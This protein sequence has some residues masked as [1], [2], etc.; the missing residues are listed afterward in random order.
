[1]PAVLIET[2]FLSNTQE[3][4]Y[5][6]SPEGLQAI[7]YSIANA[8]TAYKDTLIHQEIKTTP[9][10][11]TQPPLPIYRVQIAA[12]KN[13]TIDIDSPDI[14][15][16]GPLYTHKDGFLTKYMVGHFDSETQARK[17]LSAL[18]KLGYTDAFLVRA[19]D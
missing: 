4:Q 10:A 13:N 5:L 17:A 6:S 12:I 7:V 11:L 19:N 18:K 3:E 14:R 2:G 15:Q 8:I 9:P 16:I 1:M